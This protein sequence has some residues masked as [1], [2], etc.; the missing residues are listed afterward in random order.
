MPETSQDL[1][2]ALPEMIRRFE[3]DPKLG[4]N[5]LWTQV[6][7]AA[8]DRLAEIEPVRS[9]MTEAAR[10]YPPNELAPWTLKEYIETG[11]EY[12]LA[13]TDGDTLRDMLKIVRAQLRPISGPQAIRL[14]EALD[15]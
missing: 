3:G 14:A 12:L 2:A 11:H 4:P 8:A 5:H 9:R 13:N 6:A 10:T 1:T 15:G 7:R